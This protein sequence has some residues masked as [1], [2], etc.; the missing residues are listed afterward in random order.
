MKDNSKRMKPKHSG[1]P[2]L[3]NVEKTGSPIAV[4]WSKYSNS[5]N[6]NEFSTSIAV[7]EDIISACQTV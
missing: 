3:S 1:F 6:K 2:S 5:L 4:Q 7:Y